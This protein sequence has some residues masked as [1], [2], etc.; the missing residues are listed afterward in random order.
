MA[1][2]TQKEL[3]AAEEERKISRSMMAWVN[4]YPDL[5]ATISRV[6]FEQLPADKPG[7]ALSTIQAAYILRRYIYGGHQGEYQ[8]KVIY[9]IKPGTSNDARLKADELLNAF[10][11]WAA[12]NY[13]DLGEKIRVKR[14]EATARSSMFAVYENGDE[15]HQILMRL[16]YEVI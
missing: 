8:F 1:E 10:G 2:Q 7:M 13:P 9:R 15:D 14:V 11:D 12:Q 3:V 16:I 6:D 4:S 5:P